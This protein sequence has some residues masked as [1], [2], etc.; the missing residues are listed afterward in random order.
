MSTLRLP[1]KGPSVATRVASVCCATIFFRVVLDFL[2][3]SY[4]THFYAGDFPTGSNSTIRLLESYVVVLMLCIWIANSLYRRWRPSGIVLILYFVVVMLPLSSQYGLVDA[5]PSLMY[6]SAG[7]IAFL[8]TVTEMLPKLK[9]PK[10]NRELAYIVIIALLAI[11]IYVYGWLLFTGGATRLNWNLLKVYEV[12]AEYVE[13]LGPFM[14]Y[15]VP[16]QAYVINIYGLLSALRRRAYWLLG[17]TVLAQLFLFGMTGHKSFLLAPFLAIGVY[18]MFQKR[19]FFFWVVMGASLLT[20]AS[21]GYFLVTGVEFV[22]SLF[23]RRLFFVPARLHVLY[24]D[25]F[26]QPSHPFYMLSDSIL[27]GMVENP[28]SM[29]MVR[30]IALTYWGR[31]FWPDVGYLGDAYGNFGVLGMFLFSVILGFVLRLVDG[32]GSGLPPN[33][34]AAVI[35]MPAMALTESALFTSLLT[36]GL[37]LAVLMLW[38]TQASYVY[39]T[40]GAKVRAISS[41]HAAGSREGK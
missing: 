32:V 6:A 20:L 17:L 11:S 2:Y 33:F 35:V 22:P 5:P 14:G 3:I 13:S 21:Y 30:V 8:T 26:S 39:M 23:I 1:L 16:W 4:V 15:F 18:L 19:N 24:Y 25:F 34:V 41:H 40:K 31:E 29:P 12:R 37:I 7:S 28:Y 10:S 38:I 27:R 9:L 36:H